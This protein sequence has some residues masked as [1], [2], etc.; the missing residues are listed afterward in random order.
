MGDLYGTTFNIF[1]PLFGS[2]SDDGAIARQK[3]LIALNTEGASL[4]EFPQ[5]GFV[6][7]SQVLRAVDPVQLAM[8]PL[9]IGQALEQE[10]AFA[11][12]QA[13][14]ASA[15]QTPGGGLALA[16]RIEITG[17]QGDAVGFT[18]ATPTT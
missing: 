6:W 9:E 15:D 3:A 8:L 17:A 13:T 16:Y 18:V 7:D 14:L 5:Y 10:P 11:S 4:D 12:A 1:D 2:L